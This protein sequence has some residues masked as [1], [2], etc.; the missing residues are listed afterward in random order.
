MKSSK[1]WFFCVMAAFMVCMIFIG[2][3][4]AVVDPFFLYHAPLKCFTYRIDN[5]S[6]QN[7]G[8]VRHFD[9]ECMI[10]GSS[11]TENF[12]PSQFQEIMG[13]KTVK[14]SYSGARSK[15]LN[16]I[17]ELALK[18]NPKLK[19]VIWGL[20]NYALESEATKTRNPLPEYLYN[21][22]PFDDVRYL[23][24]KSVICNQVRTVLKDTFYGGKTTSMDDAYFWE[25][26]Y[27]FSEQSALKN[28][29]PIEKAKEVP[30]KGIFLKN[31]EENLRF[32]I[33]PLLE[34]YPSVEFDIFFPPYSILFWYER[35]QKNELEATLLEEEAAISE[36]LKYENVRLF[37]FQNRADIVTNLY[38]Y[39][40]YNHYSSAINRDMIECFQ[41]ERFMLTQ[42]NYKEQLTKMKE[43]TETFDYDLFYGDTIPFKKETNLLNYLDQINQDGHLILISAKDDASS[44]INKA[45]TEKLRALGLK[46]ELKEKFRFSYLAVLDGKRLVYEQAGNGPITYSDVVDGLEIFAE[47]KGYDVGNCSS[48]QING[49]EYSQNSRG[50]NIV[51]YDKARGR[52]VDSV[53]FD[54]YDGGLAATRN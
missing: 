24:N 41:N 19:K 38:H 13:L 18:H 45:I 9:Y 48:I 50:L 54:T 1:Q 27:H 46:E 10:V 8:I 25:P 21:E 42:S 39:K 6:Y 40:D 51:I 47:S 43:L 20:D 15:N 52:V 12:K 49:V 11:M 32:N 4:V 36:L 14:T 31:T 7:P 5:E 29:G 35:M 44:A 30:D 2:A 34:K 28:F 17:V 3:F 23:F 22:S 37:Y 26:A 33:I 16:I 53:C